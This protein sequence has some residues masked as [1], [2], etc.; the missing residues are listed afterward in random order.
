MSNNF[1]ETTRTSWGKRIMNSFAGIIIGILMFLGSFGTIWWNEGRSVDRIKT[2]EEGRGIVVSTA[3]ESINSIHQ[4]ALVHISGLTSTPDTLS[5]AQFGVVEQALKLKRK[6]ET[7]QWKQT[8][9]TKTEKN[10]GGSET[11]TTTY[12]YQKVWSE[13]LINSSGF[14]QPAGHTNPASTPYSSQLLQA[15]NVNLGA[16]GLSDSYVSQISNYESYPLT[17]A[18][19]NA[20]DDNLKK[21]FKLI[22]NEYFFGNSASPEIGAVRVNFSI[23]KPSEISVVGQQNSGVIETYKTKNGTLNLLQMKIV[24]A[25]AMFDSSESDNTFLTWAVRFGAFLLMWFG[26]SRI[27]APIRVIGDVLP[28][29]GRILGAGIGFVT[30]IIAAIL[31]FITV[32]LAWI[33]FRPLIG[34]VLLAIAALFFFGGF[35]AIKKKINNLSDNDDQPS[36][37]P[38]A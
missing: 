32:A 33:F 26:L 4:G 23:V 25:E 9:S 14:K 2:L 38:K 22:G 6:V 7:Y 20:M 24:T 34:L 21:A 15:K 5:D 36:V 11:T 1:T 16:Y 29:I 31:T 28:L 3:A 8:S 30:F 18:N 10:L 12:S 19:L 35:K 17:I 27:L 37:E 13:G